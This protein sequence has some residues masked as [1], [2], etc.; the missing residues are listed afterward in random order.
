MQLRFC[1]LGAVRELS[2]SHETD[3]PCVSIYP[4][5]RPS[6]VKEH[7]QRSAVVLGSAVL[8]I[9]SS[10]VQSSQVKSSQIKSSHADVDIDSTSYRAAGSVLA[11]LS[12]SSQVRNSV[13]HT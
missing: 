5:F 12:S 3:S 1:S 9:E 4:E 6:C 13:P 11:L 7:G 8:L 10:Q 2:L